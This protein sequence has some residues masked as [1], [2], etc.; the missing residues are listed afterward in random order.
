[1]AQIGLPVLIVARTSLGTVNHTSLT[2]RETQRT[3]VP[4]AAV[5]L[6]QTEP[7]VGPQEFGNA[8]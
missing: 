7:V 3:G 2:I 8:D 4:I 5:L 6:S 1:M